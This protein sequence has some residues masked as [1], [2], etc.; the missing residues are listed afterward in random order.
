[1]SSSSEPVADGV[2]LRHSSR[3]RRWALR[4][5]A[6]YMLLAVAT[7]VVLIASISDVNAD[8]PVMVAGGIL[9]L[10]SLPIWIT[11]A[12]LAAISL[13]RREPRPL[14]AV[15]LLVLCLVLSFAIGPIG[16]DI[17][18]GAGEAFG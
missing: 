15:G 8:S 6:T 10:V 9:S 1:M 4:L 2:V 14:I 18:R 16:L 7:V 13:V 3:F 11:V 17:L 5:F 12:V